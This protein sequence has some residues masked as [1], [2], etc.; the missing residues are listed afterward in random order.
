MLKE[1]SYVCIGHV[2][3]DIVS[4]GVILGG[5]ASYASIVG[6]RLGMKSGVVTSYAKNFEFSKRFEE[7]DIGLW[8]QESAETTSFRNIYENGNRTQFMPSRADTIRPET[9]PQF[10]SCLQ[11]V[12]L[13]LI[14]DEIDHDL[15]D[16]LP[17]DVVVGATIQGWL[18]NIDSNGLVSAKMPDL[19]LFEH[20]ELV[21]MSDDD[22]R[23]VPQLLEQIIDI[24]PIVILTRGKH[25]ADVYENGVKRTFPSFPSKEV[26]PTGA[27]DVFSTAFIISYSHNPNIA[28]ACSFAHCAASL[29]IE[30][31]GV[32]SIPSRDQVF[33]RQKL[34]FEKFGE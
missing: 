6:T 34:Y 8:V 16:S 17:S 24:V 21:F 10:E 28:R 7:Y 22:I 19:Q 2:C 12:Q 26:D 31:I 25:G 27:G 3:H 4:D 30:G 1:I 29:S 15:L 13:C 18:R 33:E 11:A 32:Q 9:L 20:I 23:E 14:A 5:T